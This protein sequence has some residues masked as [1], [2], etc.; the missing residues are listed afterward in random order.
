MR[1]VAR[2][3][4]ELNSSYND[5]CGC[6]RSIVHCPLAH[7]SRSITLN[8]DQIPWFHPITRITLP[9][10]WM[11]QLQ[12]LRSQIHICQ[13]QAELTSRHLRRCAH[14]NVHSLISLFLHFTFHRQ[15]VS[16][17]FWGFELT[18][19]FSPHRSLAFLFRSNHFLC[20][21]YRHLAI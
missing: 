15:G 5:S 20:G 19:S 10:H 4:V 18:A 9:Q 16:F 17:L 7:P 13:K 14:K 3:S 8:I 2:P 11:F 1:L 6:Q 21:A 12:W